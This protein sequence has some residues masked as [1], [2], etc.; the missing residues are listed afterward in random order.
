MMIDSSEILKTLKQIYD[1]TSSLDMLIE[2]EEILDT[3]HIYA[4]KNWIEGE[5][6][7]G[8]DVSRYWVEV[9]LMYPYKKMPDPT[10]ALRLIKHGCYVHYA[11]YKLQTSVEV[12]S[13][14]DVEMDPN[15]GK[16]KPKKEIT[17]VW[18]VK[19][20]MPRHFVDE[21]DSE[22]IKINGEEIDMSEVT[23]AYDQALDSHKKDMDGNDE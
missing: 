13:P 21:F 2:F 20:S 14:N 19:I 6:V 1:G 5:V 12:K 17:P 10:A 11:K 16:R 15:T 8:P 4:Y 3:L 18:V 7:G 23:A 22:K 9:S